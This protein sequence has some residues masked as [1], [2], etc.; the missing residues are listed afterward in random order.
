MTLTDKIRQSAVAADSDRYAC[1][2]CGTPFEHEPKTC[3]TCGS[4][5]ITTLDRV[6]GS[7]FRD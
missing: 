4:S 7:E 1:Q 5:N 6:V 2:D 3:V